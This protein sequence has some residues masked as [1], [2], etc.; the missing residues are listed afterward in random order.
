LSLKH[1]AMALAVAFMCSGWAPV[2]GQP[3][4]ARPEFEAWLGQWVTARLTAGRC[5]HYAPLVDR[6]NPDFDLPREVVLALMA[7][8]SACLPN[9]DD[10]VSVGLM[11]VTPRPWLFSEAEL[12]TPATNIYAGMFVLNGALNQAGGDMALALAAYNCGW[13]SLNAGKCINGG[14]HDYAADVLNY[15]LPIIEEGE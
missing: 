7:K 1:L 10:G 5:W 12:R 4:V 11:A 8:E 9:Q 14:G 15:W 13:E 3:T 2:D 6:W